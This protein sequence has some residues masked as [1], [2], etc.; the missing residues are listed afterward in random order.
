MVIIANFPL[1]VNDLA[2]FPLYIIYTNRMSDFFDR[3]PSGVREGIRKRMRSPEAYER[4]R[5]KVKGPEDLEK[6]MKRSEQLAE[7]HFAMESEKGIA[8]KLKTAIEKDI[9][10]QNIENIVDVADL[11]PDIRTQ[12]ETGKFT[13]SVSSH[14]STHE[15]AL[16]L[17][18]EGS[19]QEKIPVKV[20]FSEQYAGQVLSR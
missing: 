17:M 2:S 7:L 20:S 14:P 16:I 8:E 4:L 13:V 5:E 9:S 10:E 18:P 6:E 12:L 1:P 11:S 15:D 19:I 3:L